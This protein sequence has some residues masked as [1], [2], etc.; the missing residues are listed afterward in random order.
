MKCLVV[1][2]PGLVSQL[3]LSVLS[4]LPVKIEATVIHRRDAECAE[5]TQSVAIESSPGR[6][7]TRQL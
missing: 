7:T 4:V 2:R 3:Y 5:T 6:L 1:G